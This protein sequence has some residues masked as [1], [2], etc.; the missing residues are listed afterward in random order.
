M[1]QETK[2]KI[3]EKAYWMS[4]DGDYDDGGFNVCAVTVREIEEGE[5]ENEYTIETQEE[6]EDGGFQWIPGVPESE[7]YTQEEVIERVKKLLG[8]A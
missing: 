8:E 7:F 4:G 6:L 5:A 3:G 1:T 2:F